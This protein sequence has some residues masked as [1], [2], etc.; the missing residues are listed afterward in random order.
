M[1]YI[2]A[3]LPGTGK[4]TLSQRLARQLGA[5]HVRIDT[6]EQAR[7]AAGLPLEGPEGYVVGYQMA[8][9][10]LRLGLDVVADSVNPLQVTRR[11]SFTLK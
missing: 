2:F 6:I 8:P 1:L 7:R 3:G 10:N 5:V 9:D 11:W 4:S